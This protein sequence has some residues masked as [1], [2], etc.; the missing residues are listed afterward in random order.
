MSSKV[1][2][3]IP[4]YRVEYSVNRM[5][6]CFYTSLDQFLTM[7]CYVCKLTICVV[8]SST[9]RVVITHVSLQKCLIPAMIWTLDHPAHS[10]VITV[11]TAV[12]LLVH[13]AKSHLKPRYN[14]KWWLCKQVRF[15]WQC[16]WRSHSVC[17]PICKYQC[18]KWTCCL[19]QP[20][21]RRWQV[22]PN[23]W[24]QPT[25]L[26]GIISYNRAAEAVACGSILPATHCY[27]VCADIQNE[28]KFS[29]SLHD[30]AKIECW[31]NFE[32]L[33]DVYLWRNTL[34]YK[35]MVELC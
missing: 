9:P 26:H 28:K 13:I 5:S 18:C 15:S 10:T 19:L 25:R 12:H 23:L 8:F 21:R 7:F 6:F 35:F 3:L 4:S 34:Q 30:K 20:W 27:V 24:Y 2:F 14:W 16:I 32:N 22:F 11:V 1:V 31:N 17:R 29:D 33:R